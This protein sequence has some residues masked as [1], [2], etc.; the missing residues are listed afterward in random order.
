MNQSIEQPFLTYIVRS[1]RLAGFLMMQG[2]KLHA[3]KESDC[4]SGRNV[5]F[6]TK[7]QDLLNRI[8][9]YRKLK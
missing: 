2:F 9:D 3:L 6:F 5:F 4:G 7:S 8:E 1:Q